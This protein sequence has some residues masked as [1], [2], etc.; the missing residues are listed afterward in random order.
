MGFEPVD[1]L[2]VKNITEAVSSPDFEQ[3]LPV[4]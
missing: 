4:N 3:V 2:G 1:H